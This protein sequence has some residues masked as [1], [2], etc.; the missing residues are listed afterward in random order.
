MWHLRPPRD[1]PPFMANTILNFHFDYLNPSLIFTAFG[2]S[3]SSLTL[4]TLFCSPLQ[5]TN[6]PSSQSLNKHFKTSKESCCSSKL[7]SMF[8]L[9]LE[10]CVWI[11]T[12]RLDTINN[13]LFKHS[14]E[15]GTAKPSLVNSWSTSPQ[16]VLRSRCQLTRPCWIRQLW[17][18][19]TLPDKVLP[20]F[21]LWDQQEID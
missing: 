9:A 7:L 5:N 21:L 4:E 15:G 14:L 17:K 11:I 2:E 18:T 20:R 12:I 16:Q 13:T 8:G 3:R 6:Y 1:P 19:A 10:S